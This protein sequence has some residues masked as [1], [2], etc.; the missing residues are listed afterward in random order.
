MPKRLWSQKIKIKKG[1]N[2]PEYEVAIDYDHDP[3]TDVFTF[4]VSGAFLSKAE[5]ATTAV[6]LRHLVGSHRQVVMDRYSK[7]VPRSMQP[8]TN[9]S[10]EAMER[11]IVAYQGN[12]PIPLAD[13]DLHSTKD[14][15]GF[16]PHSHGVTSH[17][18]VTGT[19]MTGVTRD[20]SHS[21]TLPLAGDTGPM[22][23]PGP[24]GATGVAG[25]GPLSPESQ[26]ALDQIM[27][28]METVYGEAEGGSSIETIATAVLDLARLFKENR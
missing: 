11:M 15:S 20:H 10:V 27:E 22:G 16:P 7:V 4:D 25:P 19:V 12:Q 17:N 23:A 2:K 28:D 3:D 13:L 8:M 14:C 26:E 24:P 9:H 6:V 18:V 5:A 1:L 21:V